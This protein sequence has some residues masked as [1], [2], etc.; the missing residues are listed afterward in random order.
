VRKGGNFEITNSGFASGPE[1][2]LTTQ[3]AYGIGGGAIWR[4]D[5]G[6]NSFLQIGGMF[7]IGATNFST[8]VSLPQIYSAFQN[9]IATGRAT[10]NPDGTFDAGVNPI[11]DS[12]EYHVTVDYNWDATDNFSLHLWGIWTQNSQGFQTLGSDADGDLRIAAST[13]NIFGLGI[14]PIFW[15]AD[16][17]AIEASAFGSYQDNNRG[18]NGTD[19]FGRSGTFGIFSIGPV[20]KPKGGYFTRPELRFFATYAIWSDSLRGSTTPIN[21]G[22]NF[23][24]AIAPYNDPT[25]NQGWLFG[26]QVEWFF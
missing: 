19:T 18:Y 10:A 21:E 2:R 22:G 16:N 7:G 23:A 4:Y 11:R 9:A 17:L 15:I 12:H 25:T 6:K 26:T 13:R 3:D 20:I 24:G 1:G 5:F 14:R 8:D